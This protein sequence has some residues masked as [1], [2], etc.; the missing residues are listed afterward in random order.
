MTK[1]TRV[2]GVLTIVLAV[3]VLTAA[4]V[5]AYAITPTDVLS[6]AG[7]A[8]GI[9]V[10]TTADTVAA[11]V[12]W[13]VRMPRIVMAVLVGGCLGTSGAL[14]QGVF[15][16]PLAEPGIIGVSS[17]AAVGAV[18]AIILGAGALGS[19][20]VTA[21]AFVGGLV[22]AMVVY[23]VA[24]R[25][26]RNEV[27][28]LVLAGI[29]LN[30]IAGAAIGLAMFA[31]D[32]AEL[33]SI[34][35][36][37]LGSLGGSTWP[38]VATLAP[39]ALIGL[40]IAPRLSSS[41]DLLAL[42]EDPARHLGVDVRRLQ[43]GAVVLTALLASASVAVA[44]VITFVGLIVPHLL[45]L[46]TGPSHGVLVPASALGGALLLVLGDLVARSIAAPAELPLGVLMG[47]IGG[48]FFFWL[49]LRARERDGGWA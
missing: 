3:A 42:G 25:A 36:W 8:V 21:F 38:A 41:L 47:L 23:G 33:R 46:V 40:T 11:S 30:A 24:R 37:N 39:L 20:G 19:W 9:P 1:R 15:R 2:L 27:V 32:A 7:R 31:S 45:R 48:P 4:C 5:G 13:Q 17:G 18:S 29:A 6:L 49:L 10:T 16:N 28:T 22:A 35:F 26:G 44:G 43:L 14:M 34:T 12:L